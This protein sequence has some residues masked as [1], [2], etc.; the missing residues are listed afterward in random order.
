MNPRFEALS[1][2]DHARNAIAFIQ[3]LE[4]E[5]AKLL[6]EG[7]NQH[8]RWKE[9]CAELQGYIRAL[10][11]VDDRDLSTSLREFIHLYEH[12]TERMYRMLQGTRGN[13]EDISSIRQA[14]N[15]FDL[16]YKHSTYAI[17]SSCIPD[18]NPPQTLRTTIN[19]ATGEVTQEG[20]RGELRVPGKY[21]NTANKV[22]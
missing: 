10:G 22:W 1:S 19:I 16:A 14:L 3:V 11:Q 2:S 8:G 17:L 20:D 4:I 5:G 6:A 7:S 12:T 15:W 9:G 13:A 18:K 21:R